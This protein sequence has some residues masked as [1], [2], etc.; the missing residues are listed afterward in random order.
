VKAEITV[1]PTR[2]RSGGLV[3][4]NGVGFTPD[5]AVL[6]HLVKPNAME[7]NPLR[8]RAN[9]KGELVHKIDTVMLDIGSFEV[10]IEDEGTKTTSNRVQFVVTS[11]TCRVDF[12]SVGI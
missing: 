9:A 10:W 6:S 5:R 11:V 7:Y 2:V 1:S 8:L 4:L 3:M 12:E